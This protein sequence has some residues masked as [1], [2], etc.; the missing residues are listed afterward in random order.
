M[1]INRN[2]KLLTLSCA[3]A[4]LIVMMI[5]PVYVLAAGNASFALT[6]ASVDIG[7]RVNVSL[8]VA[9]T[10][11]T[12]QNGDLEL[13]FPDNLSFESYT[14]N[15]SVFDAYNAN[16]FNSPA[17]S[18]TV[19]LSFVSSGPESGG[20]IGTIQ[21]SGV[22][23]GT[24]E[25]T[26]TNA[27]ANDGTTE[28]GTMAVSVSN[29]TITVTEQKVTTTV[30]AEPTNNTAL[31]PET[32][33]NNTLPSDAPEPTN[34]VIIDQSNEDSELPAPEIL[35]DL[36]SEQEEASQDNPLLEIETSDSDNL[37]LWIFI[38]GAGVLLILISSYYLFFVRSKSE[39]GPSNP[40]AGAGHEDLVVKNI[41]KNN[42]ESQSPGN[43]IEPNAE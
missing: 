24:G 21:V 34:S 23:I 11:E 43:I 13:N 19:T 7:D 40:R 4:S 36:E 18:T 25:I 28:A 1:T 9:A 26:I 15:T 16:I 3:F 29:S 12:I 33:E 2:I 27:S 17:G 8:S 41:V 42:V 37:I 10:G 30:P 22:S 20:V 32:V 5:S 6:S 38:F 35:T 31:I 14:P 39:F